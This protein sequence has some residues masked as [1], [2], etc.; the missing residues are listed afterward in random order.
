MN[1]STWRHWAILLLNTREKERFPFMHKKP[2]WPE[3]INRDL[4]WSNYSNG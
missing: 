3:K 1:Y 4:Y 2:S